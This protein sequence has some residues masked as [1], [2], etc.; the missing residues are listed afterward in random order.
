MMEVLGCRR[1]A[2]PFVYLGI[3][4]GANMSRV[5]NWNPV[6][7]VIKNRLV[8]WKAKTLSM[9]GRLILIKS[10]LENLPIYYFSLYKAPKAVID[11]IEAIMRRFLWAGPS[12]DRKINWVAWD[13]ITTPK[14]EGG[15]GVNK[16][17]HV[18][19]ALLLKWAWRFKKE[20][21]ILWKKVVMG[22]HGSSRAW[23]MLPCTSSASGCWKQIVKLGEKK[24][25]NGNTHNSYFIGV[26]GD[27]STINFWADSWLRD[28]PLRLTYPHLFRLETQKWATVASRLQVVNGIK[29]ISWQWRSAP[30]S[31]EEVTELFQLLSDI[32]EFSWNGGTDKWLWKGDAQ[33]VFSV[34]KAK[35]LICKNPQSNQQTQMK[36]KGWVPLKC[37]LMV[38]RA[39]LNRLPSRV[40]LI[41]RGVVLP[42]DSCIFCNSDQETTLHM[43]TGCLFA[44]EVWSRIEFWCKLSP[45]FAFDVVDLLKTV[46]IQAKTKQSKYILRGIIFTTMWTLWI[47]RNERIFKGKRRRAIEVVESIKVTSY[48]WIRNRSR[49][50]GLD[51]LVW[52]KYPLDLM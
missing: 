22:C 25:W 21:S 31:F 32:D 23:S 28:E 49:L 45:I 44:A 20:G 1:G 14:K 26:L 4:V 43:F 17:Q 29:T 15:L 19:E 33:G 39:L 12:D 5:S 40:E 13:V 24:L 51:W 35:Q 30:A 18:N 37:K 2:F 27:G 47:E 46:N 6:I 8:S 38:W 3:K 11:S 34:S 42:N 10:V 9:G 7:E 41:R 48:F 36:W 50:K 16:L 52:C